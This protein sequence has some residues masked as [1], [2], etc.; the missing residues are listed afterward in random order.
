MWRDMVGNSA[1]WRWGDSQIRYPNAIEGFLQHNT[2]YRCRVAFIFGDDAPEEYVYF[3]VTKGKDGNEIPTVIG[4]HM[5]AF[6]NE[7]DR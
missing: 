4:E 1:G 6:E 7:W 2:P 3:I 5:F